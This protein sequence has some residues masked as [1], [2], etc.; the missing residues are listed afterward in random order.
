[1]ARVCDDFKGFGALIREIG[2]RLSLLSR[3]CNMQLAL[4]TELSSLKNITM[5]ETLT[6]LTDDFTRLN[7]HYVKVCSC[8]N[9]SVLL[10]F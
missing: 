1:V 4:I 5:P 7:E 2:N 6:S 8:P 3:S 9:C 10:E